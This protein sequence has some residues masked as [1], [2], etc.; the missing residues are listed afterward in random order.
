LRIPAPAALLVEHPAVPVPRVDGRARE[1]VPGGKLVPSRALSRRERFNA[2]LQLTAAAA[3]LAEFDLWPG[4]AAIRSSVFTR[5]SSG[6][7]ACLGRFPFTMSRVFARLGGGEGAAIKTRDA[8]IEGISEVVG[9]PRALIDVGKGEPG[10]F[11]EGGVGEVAVTAGTL[12]RDLVELHEESGA[13]QMRTASDAVSDKVYSYRVWADPNG[14]HIPWLGPQ[15]ENGAHNS[16]P[17][18]HDM[19]KG[20]RPV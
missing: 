1:S 11:L 9:L 4:L 20:P 2:A 5:S 13:T 15:G 18:I 16:E 8:A 17:P 6:I 7:Q 10:Y 3:L 14:M 12:F 19:I